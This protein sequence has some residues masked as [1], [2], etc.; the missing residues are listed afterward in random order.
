[1]FFT[2]LVSFFAY[3][4]TP[5]VHPSQSSDKLAVFNKK[6]NLIAAPVAAEQQSEALNN[7]DISG[8]W[9]G[10]GTRDQG[11][12]KRT[13]FRM[14]LELNQKGKDVTGVSI[15]HF[16]DGTK[17]YH[18]KMEIKGKLNKTFFNYIETRVMNS[19][20]IP[21]ADWCVKKVDLIYRDTKGT[22]TLEGIWDGITQMGKSCTPGRIFLQRRPPRA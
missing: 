8:H 22:P 7:L 16:E 1:M 4:T 10:S 3:Y 14:E 9:E 2:I 17:Q 18:A 15:V 6:N 20:S 13:A 21:N 5:S 19:D 12:G 11:A